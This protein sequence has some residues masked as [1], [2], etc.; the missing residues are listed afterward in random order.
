MCRSVLGIPGRLERSDHRR[1]TGNHRHGGQ[2]LTDAPASVESET[3]ASGLPAAVGRPP[4]RGRDSVCTL[5]ARRPRQ[6]SAG[7]VLSASSGE[8]G[9]E[10]IAPHPPELRPGLRSG[11]LARLAPPAHRPHADTELGRDVRRRQPFDRR[12]R[13]GLASVVIPISLS[14][15]IHGTFAVIPCAWGRRQ[16]L[17]APDTTKSVVGFAGRYWMA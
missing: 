7:F 12:S 11:Q 13:A 1:R 16:P 8:V 15:C 3:S 17:V 9:S 2:Q 4:A 5:M 14:H 10:V 6:G